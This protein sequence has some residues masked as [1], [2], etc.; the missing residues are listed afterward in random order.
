M[1]SLP[2][3][4]NG[5]FGLLIVQHAVGPNN[6]FSGSDWLFRQPDYVVH[7]WFNITSCPINFKCS[8]DVVEQGG[9]TI[10]GMKLLDYEK[11]TAPNFLAA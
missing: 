11:S 5:G 6:D 2:C 8:P 10:I 7:G 9:P 4:T 3:F 1:K